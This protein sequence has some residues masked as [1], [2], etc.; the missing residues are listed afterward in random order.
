MWWVINGVGASG[1]P[2]RPVSFSLF[3]YFFSSQS[4]R[5]VENTSPS[6]ERRI[7]SATSV[8][9]ITMFDLRIRLG[10][11]LS[12]AALAN[13]VEWKGPKPTTV[14]QFPMTELGFSP[15]PTEAPRIRG[16]MAAHE[17]FARQDDPAVLCGYVS[18]SI[19]RKILRSRAQVSS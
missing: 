9:K 14:D 2:A 15:K 1:L 12:L 13:A 7:S 6:F 16:R 18:G 8:E 3:L 17:L 4:P 19:G 11:V 5:G 10:C